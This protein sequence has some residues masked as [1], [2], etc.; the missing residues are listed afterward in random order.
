[1]R[2]NTLGVALVSLAVGMAVDAVG[3]LAVTGQ[4]GSPSVVEEGNDRRTGNALAK[5]CL[6]AR[7]SEE[8]ALVT[9]EV[10][11]IAAGFAS[12]VRRGT[13]AGFERDKARLEE[14]NTDVVDLAA[15]MDAARQSMQEHA[16]LLDGLRPIAV[17]S[18][19]APNRQL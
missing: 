3:A 15:R 5:P 19:V 17:P 13:G 18:L 7:R 1:M 4:G 6:V 9:A 10:A 2:V 12:L 14:I 8:V 16:P 11:L